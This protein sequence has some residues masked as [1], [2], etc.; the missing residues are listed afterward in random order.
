MEQKSHRK[1]TQDEFVENMT[2]IV[3]CCK[4]GVHPDVCVAL[5]EII[6]AR[7]LAERGWERGTIAFMNALH[8]IRIVARER[9]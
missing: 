4:N 2:N 3:E 9:G 1:I 7:A 6:A 8:D 5:A